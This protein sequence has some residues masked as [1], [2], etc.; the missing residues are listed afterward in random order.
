M[1]SG[2][3]RA[4]R[5]PGI[6]ND[7]RLLERQRSQSGQVFHLEAHQGALLAAKLDTDEMDRERHRGVLFASD[8]AI[9]FFRSQS[10]GMPATK[11]PKSCFS[12]AKSLAEGIEC[13][14]PR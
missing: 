9:E 4:R 5:A 2:R 10:P 12:P 7:K 8:W 14:D 11:V 6:G 3:S 13:S 1:W